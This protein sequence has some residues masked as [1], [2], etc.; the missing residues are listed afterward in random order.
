MPTLVGLPANTPAEESFSPAG[1]EPDT[2]LNVGAGCPLAVKV[3]L[4][5][6]PT[7]P[8]A[9]G[10]PL[11]MTGTTGRGLTFTVMAEVFAVPAEFVAEIRN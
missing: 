4:Y 5:A 6:T 10:A 3:K 11:V 2:T 9:G 1:N 8:V 7:L